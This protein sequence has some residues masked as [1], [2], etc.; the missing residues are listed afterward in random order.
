[1]AAGEGRGRAAAEGA[2]G[3]SRG[4]VRIYRTAD[5]YRRYSPENADR[6]ASL[7]SFYKAFRRYFG[8]SVLDLGCGGGALGAVIAPSGRSYLGVDTNPDMLREARK[9]TGLRFLEADITRDRIPGRFDT[10]TLIGNAM[11]HFSVGQ[12]DKLLRARRS[13]VHVGSTFL[14][15][16]R[17]LIA[18]F[19]Q[20]TWT[21]V[22]V[23]TH[24]RGKIVH[25]ARL[26]DLVKG[27]LDVR[28]RPSTRAWVLDWSHAIWS[29]FILEMLMRSHGWVLVHR[30][31]P[32]PKTAAARIPE[33]NVDVYR[34]AAT[35]GD[36]R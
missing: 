25:R 2:L 34:F 4:L 30:S 32:R 7:T 23:T 35:R 1:M 33:S 36:Y 22:R 27:T 10:V 12:M 8:R 20:N 26:L 5:D 17:D 15:E 19:W 6:R 31:P 18:M 14:L 9:L 16:Y 13:N 3:V 21:H 24:V 29:P 28:A 11:A